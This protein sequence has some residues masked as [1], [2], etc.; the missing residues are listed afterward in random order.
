MKNIKSQDIIE[1]L[2]TIIDMDVSILNRITD[3]TKLSTLGLDSLK[4]IQLVV[5]LEEKYQVEFNDNNLLLDNLDTISKI[6][7]LLQ[8]M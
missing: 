3:N 5:I 7:D 6:K 4:A 1:I 2:I 8:R